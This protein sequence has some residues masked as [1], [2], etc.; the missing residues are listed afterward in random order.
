MVYSPTARAS[1]TF[2]SYSAPW[3]KSTEQL[4]EDLRQGSDVENDFRTLFD[5][6][7]GRVY[8]FFHRKGF[9]PEDCAD[10]SQEVFLSVY[11]GVKHLRDEVKFQSWIFTLARNAFINEVERKHAQKR[12]GIDLSIE[13]DTEDAD[14][15]LADSLPGNPRE[16]PIRIVLEKEKQQRVRQAVE[17]LPPQMRRCMH[18]RV[19]NDCSYE[20]IAVI[21]GRPM[22]TVK[23]HL[24]KAREVLRDKLGPYYG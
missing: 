5:R 2:I 4:I 9:S 14:L 21:I 18:L 15:S 1:E 16:I 10:L 11:K 20:E 24:F 13:E 17:E 6:Y 22:N 12:D 23:A 8:R 3:Q 7:Y 19:L